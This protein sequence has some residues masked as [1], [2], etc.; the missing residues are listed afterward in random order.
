MA[1]A[2]LHMTSVVTTQ[3]RP[4]D[5]IPHCIGMSEGIERGF[6]LFRFF[7]KRRCPEGIPSGFALLYAARLPVILYSDEEVE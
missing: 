6:C 3:S 4:P 5:A 2:A 7:I 1:A